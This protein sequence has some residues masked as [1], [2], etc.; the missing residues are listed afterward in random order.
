MRHTSVLHQIAH[1][2]TPQLIVWETF[3]A[4]K[5]YFQQYPHALMKLEIE[6]VVIVACRY[7]SHPTRAE[8]CEETTKKQNEEKIKPGKQKNDKYCILLVLKRLLK[9]QWEM[10]PWPLRRGRRMN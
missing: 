10:L 1:T 6:S 8:L 5:A 9:K 4:L 2:W 7:I 3:E